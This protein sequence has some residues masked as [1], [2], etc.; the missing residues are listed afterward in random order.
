MRPE[1]P[2]IEA[3]ESAPLVIGF[4]DLFDALGTTELRYSD[5]ARALSGRA[6]AIDGFL[7]QPHVPLAAP[8]LVDQ[9]GVCPDCSPVPA[10]AIA[11]PGLRAAPRFQAVST[12]GNSPDDRPVRIVG[13]LDFGFRITDGTA[14]MLRI[15]HARVEPR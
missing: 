11:L 14:S 4:S 8:M 10:A 9:P 7:S 15:E 6:I 13:R 3:T 1:P 5:R 12:T 2:D